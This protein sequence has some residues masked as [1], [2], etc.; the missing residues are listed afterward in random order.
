MASHS[1]EMREAALSPA[2]D[3][4]AVDAAKVMAMTVID[5]LTDHSILEKAWEELRQ[6]MAARK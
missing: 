1:N 2:G 3:R 4:G 5:L 6:T